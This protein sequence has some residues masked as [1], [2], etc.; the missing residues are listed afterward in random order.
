M[1]P[2]FPNLATGLIAALPVPRT[3]YLFEPNTRPKGDFFIQPIALT[4]GKVAKSAPVESAQAAGFESAPSHDLN[5][6]VSS[7]WF[8]L[9][10]PCSGTLVMSARPST[11]RPRSRKSRVSRSS[12]PTEIPQAASSPLVS[13]LRIKQFS[14]LRQSVGQPLVM[15]LPPAPVR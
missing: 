15:L 9:D 6:V 13:T 14:A 1:R 8:M 5:S 4:I 7:V 12:S 10:V 2:R 11:P 3:A